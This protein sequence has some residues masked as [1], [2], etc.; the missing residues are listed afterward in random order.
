MSMGR[1]VS[2]PRLPSCEL[3]IGG[4]VGGWYCKQVGGGG[5]GGGASES[6]GICCLVA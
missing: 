4:Q 5:E 1:R 2:I 3:V 6:L